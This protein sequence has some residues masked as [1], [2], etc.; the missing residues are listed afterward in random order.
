MWA[1]LNMPMVTLK[2]Q[3]ASDNGI[4]LLLVVEI[5]LRDLLNKDKLVQAS[6][7]SYDFLKRAAGA[8]VI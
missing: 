8:M 5:W 4:P 7:F 1:Y 3:R 6:G 2:M